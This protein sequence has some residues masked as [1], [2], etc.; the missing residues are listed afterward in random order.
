MAPVLKKRPAFKGREKDKDEEEIQTPKQILGVPRLSPEAEE[1]I[2]LAPRTRPTHVP[3]TM[4]RYQ[5]AQMAAINLTHAEIE[6]IIGIS[7]DT[8]YKYYRKELDFG[9]SLCTAKVAARLFKVATEA[10]GREAITAM[11][12]WLKSRAG[13]RDDNKQLELSGPDG[14]PIE[15]SALALTNE[16]RAVR[17]LQL[18][19]TGAVEGAG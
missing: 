17:L 8:L 7:R 11:I 16:E 5:V 19:N 13:W 1:L 15:F 14:K 12:F 10:E 4:S 6:S 2:S 3:T 9:K 18:L